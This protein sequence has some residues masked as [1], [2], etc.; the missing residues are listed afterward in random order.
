MKRRIRSW[1]LRKCREEDMSQS[2]CMIIFRKGVTFKINY[3][4]DSVRYSNN[5]SYLLTLRECLVKFRRQM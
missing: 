5:V 1:T 3:I 2:F 4:R